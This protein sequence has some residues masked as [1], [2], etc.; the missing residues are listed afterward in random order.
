MGKTLYVSREYSEATRYF[1]KALVLLEERDLAYKFIP[2]LLL[3]YSYNLLKEKNWT[4]LEIILNKSIEK[5][6]DFTDLYYIY[7]SW[8]IEEKKIEQFNLLPS[9]YTKCLEIGEA[10]STK[11]ETTKGVGSFK[12]LYNLG[13]YYEITGNLEKAMEC[14]NLSSEMNYVIAKNRL[15]ILSKK[16]V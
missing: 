8:I 16:F 11:Y 4:E 7:A 10:D 14:Y 5:Y 2:N 15:D 1:K 3:Q 9:L 12:A 6:P 13:L